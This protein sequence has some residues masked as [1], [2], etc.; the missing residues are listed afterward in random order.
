M[1]HNYFDKVICLTQGDRL[2]RWV[3][4]EAEC[5][6]IGLKSEKFIAIPHENRFIS[7]CNSQVAMLRY[8]YNSGAKTALTLE[9]D[10]QFKSMAHFDQVYS[11][12]WD[13]LYLGCNPTQVPEKIHMHAYRIHGAW[14]THAVGYT[15][16]MMKFI[17]DYYKGWEKDGMYDDWLAR[18]VHPKFRAI[19]AKPFMAVQRPVRSDLWQ[20]WSEYDFKGMEARLT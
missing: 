12:R 4:F 2:D 17:L 3:Q 14:T 9:D 6:R 7:F 11:E 20:G 13:M 15:R 16:A 19:C 5:K 18:K 1:L 10:V 8:M